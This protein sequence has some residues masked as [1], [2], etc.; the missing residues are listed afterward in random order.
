[1]ETGQLKAALRVVWIIV[2][3]LAVIPLSL[4]YALSPATIFALAESLAVPHDKPC[5]LCGMTGSFILIAHGQFAQALAANR[6]SLPLY[7]LLAVSAIVAASYVVSQ[8]W[9]WY[10]QE[11]T[12]ME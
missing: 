6:L 8:I 12:G 5:L 7:A 11:R 9:R 3:L 2:S 4:P 10:E 1:M